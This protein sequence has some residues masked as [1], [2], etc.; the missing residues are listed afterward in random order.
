MWV[1]P[2]YVFLSLNVGQ[3]AI[4]YLHLGSVSVTGISINN[5]QR[6]NR[7]SVLDLKLLSK[8]FSSFNNPGSGRCSSDENRLRTRRM[9]GVE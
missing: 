9:G 4:T 5:I 3:C 6:I 7:V 2:C 1:S 8:K